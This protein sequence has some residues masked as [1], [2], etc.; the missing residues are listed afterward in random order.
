MKRLAAGLALFFL[1]CGPVIGDA[2]TVNS[3]CGAGVCVNRAF[4]PGGMCSLLCTN[5]A[6]CPAGSVCVGRVIDADADGCLRACTA[7]SE[8]RSGYECRVE[9]GSSRAV[10]LGAANVP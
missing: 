1:S 8:C 5:D 4:A 7:A 3:D 2:C 10:C 6:S 9:N